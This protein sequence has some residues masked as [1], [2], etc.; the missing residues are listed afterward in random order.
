MELKKFEIRET[1]ENVY[2]YFDK[3]TKEGIVVDPGGDGEKINEFIKENEL[4]IKGIFL[5]HG[6]YDHI[7]GVEEVKNYTKAK[8]YAHKDE[9]FVLENGD[10]NLSSL[11]GS[12]G[13]GE[14]TLSAN[15]LL[16]DGDITKFNNFEIKTIH[17]PGHTRGGSCFLDEKNNVLFTGD[18]LF[19]GTHG[20][21]D[22]PTSNPRLIGNSIKN[23]LFTLDDK[24]KVYPGH[25]GRT[26][27]GFEK[28]NN[29]N[30]NS[31]KS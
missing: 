22:L 25:M 21:T 2:V 11:R 5:T 6:H 17:T 15:R 19:K 13:V 10:I 27:I 20:R 18:T 7:L 8:V 4:N 3:E 1:T 30:V 24:T 23:K 31:L 26:T 28:A 16:N 14:V 29:H 9:Q 12:K